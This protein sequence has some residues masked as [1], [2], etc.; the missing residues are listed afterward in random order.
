ML[1]GRKV[2]VIKACVLAGVP[3]A[4]AKR[5]LVHDKPQVPRVAGEPWSDQDWVIGSAEGLTAALG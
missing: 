1:G 4:V 3:A 5:G 2:C